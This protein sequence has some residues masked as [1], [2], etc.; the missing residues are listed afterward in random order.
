M[1][2]LMKMRRYKINIPDPNFR[3]YLMEYFDHDGNN[4]LTNLDCL[5]I[6][7]ISCSFRGI[8]S[9]SGIEYFPN[10]ETL[11]CIGNEFPELILD[12]HRK[13]KILCCFSD[14]L[15]KLVL[16]DCPNLVDLQCSGKNLRNLD[17]SNCKNIRNSV[18]L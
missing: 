3:Y 16:S 13:L 5:S 12:N 1:S 18:L 2:K 7:T 15:E 4:Y 14:K 9:M 10:L 6:K 17:L 8:K 11:F